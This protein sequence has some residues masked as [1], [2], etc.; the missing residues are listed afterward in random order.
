MFIFLAGCNLKAT[1]TPFIAPFTRQNTPLPPT[2]TLTVQPPVAQESP[3]PSP[4]AALPPGPATEAAAPPTAGQ[5]TPTGT[6]E[7]ASPTPKTCSDSMVFVS[8]ISYPDNTQVNPGQ[9]IEKQW[10][11]K[12][13][14]TCDWGQGYRLKLVDGYPALGAESE[15]ALFPARA[16]AQATITI[17]FTA[18]AEA[19]YYRTAWQAY[20]PEGTA[21][22]DVIYMIILIGQ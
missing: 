10:K 22:G 18:P 17:N 8:D 21:F 14:G 16:G 12:N 6:L 7:Q 15:Q 13:N 1:A 5:P 11:V 9:A 4:M 3:T 19:G 2:E 20:S